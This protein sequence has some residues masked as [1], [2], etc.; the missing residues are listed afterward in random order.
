MAHLF[1]LIAA[2]VL[3]LL[4][5]A[6]NASFPAETGGKWGFT[7]GA[8]SSGLIYGSADEACQAFIARRQSELP[9][10]WTLTFE[11][12]EQVSGGNWA[13]VWKQKDGRF[14]NDAPV[15][16]TIGLDYGTGTTC[17]QN[18]TLNGQTCT[19]NSG[20]FERNVSGKTACV[21]PDDR[22]PDQLCNDAAVL[23]NSTLNPDRFMR[24]Q[25]PLS[26]YA[27]GGLTCAEVPGLPENVGCKHWFTGDL[28]F[29]DDQGRSWVNGF[30]VGLEEGS[31]R[32]GGGLTCSLAEGSEPKKEN[33]P[34]EDC[35]QGYKGQVNGVD[36]CVEAWTG[37]TEGNDWSRNTDGQGNKTDNKTN[38]KCK[39]DQCTVTETTTTTKPDGTTTTHTTTTENVN[40]QTYCARNPESSVCRR[41][42]DT[43]GGDKGPA[44]RNPGGGGD[45]DGDGGDGWCKQNPNSPKCRD[46]TFSGSC[47][48]NF[49]CDGDAIQCA[50]AKE[51]HIRACQLFDDETPESKLYFEES[52]K[53]K[54][55]DVTKN[56]PG[57]ETVDVGSKLRSDDLLGGAACVADLGV[58]VMG[59]PVTLP[60]SKICPI[61]GYLGWILVA[62]ASLA[63]FRILSG[64]T[65]KE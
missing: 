33:K 19:C 32:A 40:R 23:W 10:Y 22:T 27:D 25:G 14:P 26:A 61:L 31:P 50:I 47:A 65:P 15:T 3:A 13:C 7:S 2:L 56:L 48:A 46:S 51:Q 45:G 9:S 59:I 44:T 11:R 29:K 8:Y 39:G 43:S 5:Q 54:S 24:V 41:E 42:D 34:P 52:A 55:R 18:A 37:D 60:M 64:T 21:K 35:K 53:D 36:V 12:T 58:T 28:A 17:P 57:N 38:I 16:N 4:A 20:F 49:Q 63:G 6:S 30:S 1:R 62:V